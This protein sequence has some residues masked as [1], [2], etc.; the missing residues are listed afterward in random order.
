MKKKISR[1]ESIK[2]KK[3]IKSQYD[4]IHEI[5]IAFSLEEEQTCMFETC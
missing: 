2:R 1:L 5:Y 3:I 4:V